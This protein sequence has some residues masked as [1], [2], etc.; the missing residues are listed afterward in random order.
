MHTSRRDLETLTR[1][2]GGGGVVTGDGDF[3]AQDEP[4]GVEV[5]AMIGRNQVRL[6]AAVYDAVALAPEVCFEFDAIH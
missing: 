6:Q 2:E 5:M 3:A 4:L 1:S